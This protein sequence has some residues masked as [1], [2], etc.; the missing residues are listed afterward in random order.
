M[1]ICQSLIEAASGASGLLGD[2]RERILQI[3]RQRQLPDGGFRGKGKTSALYYTGFAVL[4]FLAM[5]G[6]FDRQNASRYAERFEFAEDAD[7]AHWAAWLRLCRLLRPEFFNE[8]AKAACMERLERFACADG[9]WHHLA[10]G[11]SGSAY[12]CF[13]VMGAMQDMGVTMSAETASAIMR[14]IDSLRTPGGGYFNEAD[15]PAVSVPATAAA[16]V[17]R[18]ILGEDSGCDV[19]AAEWLRRCYDGEGFRVM[20]MAPG[21]D[22][23]STAVALHSLC[24]DGADISGI[25]QTCLA[26]VNSLWDDTVGFCANSIDRL[27]DTEYMFYGLLALGHL[28]K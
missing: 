1:N 17:V 3:L 24:V 21:A 22:L 10:G 18:R 23:L 13:L 5:G 8:A 27:S 28:L 11:Q 14:C 6:E 20:P 12:G 19:K 15:I 25:R 7:L 4:A 9:A 26:Y 2:R 16:M